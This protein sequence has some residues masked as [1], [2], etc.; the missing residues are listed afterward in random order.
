MR[1]CHPTGGVAATVAVVELRE[2][3][4]VDA[5]SPV[6]PVDDLAALLRLDAA[7]TPT[8]FRAIPAT[9]LPMQPT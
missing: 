1:V 9:R 3:V 6:A 5:C 4:V 2:V 7:R 8:L